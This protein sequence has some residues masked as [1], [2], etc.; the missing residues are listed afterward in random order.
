MSVWR[1]RRTWLAA[2]GTY[3]PARLRP[4]TPRR[5]GGLTAALVEEA[6]AHVGGGEGARGVV[7]VVLGVG[8]H[9]VARA[10][11]EERGGLGAARP[12]LPGGG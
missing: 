9:A 12:G 4:V 5:H 6:R 7:A 3:L 2:W 10:V 1:A 11:R 8:E